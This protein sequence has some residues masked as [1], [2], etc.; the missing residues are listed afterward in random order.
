MCTLSI[1]C[2]SGTAMVPVPFER[3]IQPP[4]EQNHVDNLIIFNYF[5][6]ST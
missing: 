1:G 5:L 6:I 2:V 3:I 4:Y